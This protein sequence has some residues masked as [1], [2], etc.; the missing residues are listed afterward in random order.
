MEMRNPVSAGSTQNAKV[1]PTDLQLEK[2]NKLIDYFRSLEKVAV[3]FSS[4]V[5]STFLLF[6]AKEA[7]KENVIAVTIISGSFP[8]REYNEAKAYCEEIGVKQFFCE[9]KEMEIEG[10]AENPANRCY[11]CKNA[12]FGTMLKTVKEQGYSKVVE[13]S[14]K[15]DEG[16]YRPGLK[17]VAELG[18]KSPLRELGFTKEDI[19]V[20]SKY[21]GIPTWNKQSFACLATRFVYGE[22]ITTEK[23]KMVDQAEQLLMD[24]GFHQLRVR[25]HGTMARIE[26]VPE[27]FG[28]MMEE[29]TRE[30]VVNSFKAYGFSYVS[31]DLTGYRTGSMNEVLDWKK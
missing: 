1:S 9:V 26:I 5:D 10:F 6:A 27:E 19:R 12:M 21:L 30:L 25:I 8:K 28:K 11:L 31:M 7:L 15:D 2:Y 13:G 22:M 29:K 14:N 23:L 17:A 4:G 20:L 24:L 16:D 3:A 18:V